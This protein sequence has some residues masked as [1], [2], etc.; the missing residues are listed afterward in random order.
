MGDVG[1]VGDVGDEWVASK[2]AKT[3]KVVTFEVRVPPL[4]LTSLPVLP[5]LPP[6]TP[7]VTPPVT[8]TLNGTWAIVPYV[9]RTCGQSR[10]ARVDETEGNDEMA[11][12]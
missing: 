4:S 10:S 6:I 3:A 8:P 2:R 9:P 11:V 1:D 12:D 5:A 7:P